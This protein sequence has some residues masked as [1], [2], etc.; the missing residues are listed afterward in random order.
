MKFTHTPSKDTCRKNNKV[1]GNNDNDMPNCA[2]LT[3]T[4]QRAK[5]RPL[6]ISLSDSLSDSFSDSFCSIPTE[7]NATISHATAP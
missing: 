6:D 7:S 4:N 5:R 3:P 2:P 1:M